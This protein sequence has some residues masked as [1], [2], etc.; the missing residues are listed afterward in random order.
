MHKIVL[1]NGL[2]E[3]FL[4]LRVEYERALGCLACTLSQ[5][6]RLKYI[7]N[8]VLNIFFARGC[9]SI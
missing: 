8:T 2:S 6:N 7:T 3:Q 4:K 1:V 9:V 5:L